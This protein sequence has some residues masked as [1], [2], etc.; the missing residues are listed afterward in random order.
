[1]NWKRTLPAWAAILFALPTA[2]TAQ[3]A[4]PE[5]TRTVRFLPVGDAPPFRQEIRDGVRYELDAPPGSVPPREL[6]LGPDAPADADA[7]PPL[8]LRLGMPSKPLEV[9]AGP[10]RLRLFH[11]DEAAAEKAWLDLKRP[12]AGDFLVLLWRDPAGG[13]WDQVS[14]LCVPD[15]PDGAPA[16]T[17]R[18]ANLFPQGVR[19]EWNGEPGILKA[20]ETIR[21]EVTPGRPALLRVLVPDR[22][23]RL[24]RF[25]A[26]EVMQNAGE[27]SFV[28]I[29][30]ADGVAPRRPLKVA[31]IREPAPGPA[32]AG[33]D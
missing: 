32:P 19:I 29:Y 17:V 18:I 20:G 11:P 4:A 15:G 2:A 30:R 21:R 13:G 24:R 16:G 33:D 25:F 12:D 5:K 7:P 9:P 31:V 28:I 8:D 14:H 26:G 3:Q 27:R 10:G 1:M 22:T 6:V 23:G